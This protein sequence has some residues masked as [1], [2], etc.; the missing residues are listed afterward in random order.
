AARDRQPA[1]TDDGERPAVEPGAAR[2]RRTVAWRVHGG[3]FGGV[4]PGGARP[5]GGS[6]HRRDDDRIS[7]P[8]WIEAERRQGGRAHHRCASP[9][10]RRRAA[11]GHEEETAERAEPAESRFFKERTF[12]L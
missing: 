10:A 1:R 6:A 12:D 3:L 4:V 9:R 11:I 2:A 5:L 8:G 7:R